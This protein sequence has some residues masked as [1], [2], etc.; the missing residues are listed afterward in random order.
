M[1]ELGP[2]LARIADAQLEKGFNGEPT[3]LRFAAPRLATIKNVG[4]S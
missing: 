4:L 1:R 3:T 2:F